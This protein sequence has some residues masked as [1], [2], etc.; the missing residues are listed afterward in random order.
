MKRFVLIGLL[1]LLAATVATAWGTAGEPSATIRRQVTMILEVLGDPALHTDAAKE[2]KKAKIRAIADEVFN[3]DELSRRTLGRNWQQLN[4]EQQRE[5]TDLFGRLLS[6]VYL[7]RILEYTNETV[8]FEKETMLATDKAE[9]QS[10]IITASKSIPVHYRM[11]EHNGQWQVYDVII[12]GV[13]LVK[14][15]RS[16]FKDILATKSPEKLLAILREKTSEA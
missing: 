3:Y 15:Y 9:V 4:S 10:S 7:D 11:I 8:A 6:K 1:T 12:E 16:Q 2:E 14:N 13:S 5:F